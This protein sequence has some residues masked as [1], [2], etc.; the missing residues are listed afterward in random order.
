MH[1]KLQRLAHGPIV[2]FYILLITDPIYIVNAA[3]HKANIPCKQIRIRACGHDVWVLYDDQSGVCA[4]FGG[5]GGY[6]VSKW[7][8]DDLLWTVHY[9]LKGSVMSCEELTSK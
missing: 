5:F 7:P 9:L 3:H 6:G 4:R 2:A 1:A 8:L